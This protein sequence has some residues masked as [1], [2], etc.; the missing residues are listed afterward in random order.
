M[1]I[2]GYEQQQIEQANATGRTAVDL[3][4]G[5]WLLPSSW[6]RAADA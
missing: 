5:L 4:H 3:I 2:T 1:A 6:D